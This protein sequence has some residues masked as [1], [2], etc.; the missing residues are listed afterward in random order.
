[1]TIQ[2]RT[3]ATILVIRDLFDGFICEA[4]ETSQDEAISRER[5]ALGLALRR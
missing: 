4:Y 5:E 2:H 3:T 1:L